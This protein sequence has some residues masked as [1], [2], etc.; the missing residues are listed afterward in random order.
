MKKL[1]TE[2]KTTGIQSAAIHDYASGALIG[3]AAANWDAYKLWAEGHSD[4]CAA[5]RCLAPEVIATL[6][7]DA[8]RTIFLLDVGER[9]LV[10]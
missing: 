7:I 9:P 6:G 2:T 4:V 8:A 5:H 3:K 1:T 10:L